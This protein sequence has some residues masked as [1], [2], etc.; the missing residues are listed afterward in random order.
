MKTKLILYG[1]SKGLTGLISIISVVLLTRILNS[2]QYGELSL[3]ISIVTIFSSFFYQWI[4]VSLLRFNRSDELLGNDVTKPVFFLFLISS[5]IVVIIMFTLGAFV[6]KH[7]YSIFNIIIITCFIIFLG[8]YTIVVQFLNAVNDPKS[9]ASIVALKSIAILILSLIILQ[10][11]KTF[12]SVLI[13]N[14]F[15]LFAI[16]VYYLRCFISVDSLNVFKIKMQLKEFLVYGFP[17]AISSLFILVIDLSDRFMISYF[18][19]KEQLGNYSAPY[20]LVQQIA[21]AAFNIL[22]LAMFPLLIKAYNLSEKEKYNNLLKKYFDFTIFLSFIVLVTFFS[23]NDLISNLFF[24]LEFRQTAKELIPLVA[25]AILFG[26]I[27]SNFIDL[28]LKIEKKTNTLLLISIFMA[29]S[30]VLFNYFLI[31]LIGI[32]GGVLSTLLAFIIGCVFSFLFVK[33]KIISSINF[34]RLFETLFF[35]FAIIILFK[36]FE[37]E[38]IILSNVIANL[39]LLGG[40]IFITALYLNFFNIRTCLLRRIK[41]I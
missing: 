19:G 3:A 13:A 8:F 16:S 39:L 37:L 24:G 6:L 33:S 12:S 22:T 4:S 29:I 26:S 11:D 9:F 36:Y 34:I 41:G 14:S 28:P 40:M 17:L 2:E 5:S 21:G 15:V 1:L 25:I 35:A 31:P 38:S 7:S 30:N 18:L 20:D 10:Y 23:L 27:K 32:K